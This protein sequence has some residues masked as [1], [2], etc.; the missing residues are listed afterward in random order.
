MKNILKS[1]L[2]GIIS[3]LMVSGCSSIKV[4]S[5]KD[6]TV[7]FS[8]FKTFEYF[9][10]ADESDKILN[11]FDK[12]RIEKAFGIEFG[13]R[14]LTYVDSGGDVIV[15]LF[16]VAEQKTKTTATTTGMGGMYGGYG[17]YRSYGPG[18]GWGGGMTTTTYQDYDS[19]VGTL[20]VD[21]Y[22]AKEKHLIWEASGSRTVKENTKGRE[23]RIN[24]SVALIMKKYPVPAAK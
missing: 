23:E 21:M 14:G 4:I 13:K 5:D 22:D 15:T 6:S 12:E 18:Y 2:L 8:Q 17:G 1:I 3:F 9:G 7:D 11:R 19:V 20:V 10:W 16:I 24:N